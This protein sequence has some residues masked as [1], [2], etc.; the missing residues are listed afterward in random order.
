MEPLRVLV[1]A[2]EEPVVLERLAEEVDRV[3][4]VSVALA[5]QLRAMVAQELQTEVAAVVVVVLVVDLRLVALVVR[6]S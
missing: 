2:A 5:V 4:R 1:V 3:R 6:A